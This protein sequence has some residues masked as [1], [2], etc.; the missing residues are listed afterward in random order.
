MTKTYSWGQIAGGLLILSGV[1]NLIMGLTN[2]LATT[3]DEQSLA[4]MMRLLVQGTTLAA[5]VLA[6]L[7]GWFLTQR[8]RWAYLLGYVLVLLSLGF[9]L[10][11]LSQL[12]STRWY[13]LAFSILIL[14]SLVLSKN[15]FAK[16][17]LAKVK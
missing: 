17:S 12:G 10:L 1:V 3:T 13:G 11:T 16:H 15:E 2:L 5:A 6:F 4:A 14:V 8:K 7:I 9:H